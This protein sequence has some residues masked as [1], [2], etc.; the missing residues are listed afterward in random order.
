MTRKRTAA[1]PAVPRGFPLFPHGSG[2][3]AKKIRGKLFYFGPWADR[4]KALELYGKVAHDLYGGRTPLIGD[5]DALI[6]EDGINLALGAKQNAVDSGELSE[7]MQADYIRIGKRVA[8]LL[9]RDRPIDSL[10]PEDFARVRLALAD[11]VTLKTLDNRIRRARVLFQYLANNGLLRLPL[12]KIWGTEFRP[13]R[14]SKLRAER[15][16]GPVRL[17][18][19]AAFRKL[20]GKCDKPERAML[21]LGLNCAFGNTDIGQLAWHNLDLRKGWVELPR[22]KTETDR[23]CPLWSDTVAALRKLPNNWGPVF[24]LYPFSAA[25]AVSHKF[26]TIRQNAG[27]EISGFYALRHTFQTVAEEVCPDFPAIRS[28]MGHVDS[29]MSAHYREGISDKRLLA[30][31]NAVRK[32]AGKIGR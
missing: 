18:T 2:Q 8:D 26:Q 1:K 11:G 25:S 22:Q 27:V 7:V 9:G 14:K 10:R 23:R 31:T 29:S 6:V 32:W 4:V 19:A 16:Q 17:L 3:W 5:P 13:P 12:G 28:I 21:L 30:V 20:L 15:A 24:D